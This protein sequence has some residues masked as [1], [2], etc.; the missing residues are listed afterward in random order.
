MHN[1]DL[2]TALKKT[3]KSYVAAVNQNNVDEAKTNLSKVYKKL[4]KAA[5]VNL[6]K[7]NTAARQKSRLSRLIVNKAS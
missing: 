4:D 1:Q 2:K 3:I 6:L 5:K 7:P